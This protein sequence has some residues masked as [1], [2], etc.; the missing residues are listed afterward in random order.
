MSGSTVTGTNPPPTPTPNPNNDA[1]ITSDLTTRRWSYHSLSIFHVL[2]PLTLTFLYLSAYSVFSDGPVHE[3]YR[4]RKMG[5][6]LRVPAHDLLMNWAEA[7][8]DTTIPQNIYIPPFPVLSPTPFMD[9]KSPP[10][11]PLLFPFSLLRDFSSW[12][13]GD[14]YP[15]ST[16]QQF[17]GNNPPYYMLK[18]HLSSG[19]YGATPE[20]SP[21]KNG[22]FGSAGRWLSTPNRILR[23]FRW[24]LTPFL[25]EAHKNARE[26][27]I[28][29]NSDPYIL[30][31]GGRGVYLAYPSDKE[32]ILSIPPKCHVTADYTINSLFTAAQDLLNSPD[33]PAVASGQTRTAPYLTAS[34]GVMHPQKSIKATGTPKVKDVISNLAFSLSPL[35]DALIIAVWLARERWLGADSEWAPY[36]R[37]LPGVQNLSLEE[38]E[39]VVKKFEGK[40]KRFGSEKQNPKKS[41]FTRKM[42]T[43]EELFLNE[44]PPPPQSCGWMIDQ[45]HLKT[46]LQ[47][48]HEKTGNKLDGW[49]RETIGVRD[50]VELIAAGMAENVGWIVT[51]GIPAKDGLVAGEMVKVEPWDPTVQREGITVTEM[52]M[53]AICTVTNRGIAGLEHNEIK[54]PPTNDLY[55]QFRTHFEDMSL[56]KGHDQPP[57]PARVRLVPIMDMVNHDSDSVG[58]VELDTKHPP[59]STANRSNSRRKW[60]ATIL[61]ISGP[62]VPE[63][64]LKSIFDDR[65]DATIPIRSDTQPSGGASKIRDPENDIRLSDENLT[66]LR[67]YYNSTTHYAKENETPGTF[68]IYRTSPTQTGELQINYNSDGFSFLDWFLHFGF[69]PSSHHREY[70]MT[71]NTLGSYNVHPVNRNEFK[72]FDGD[73]YE[74]HEEVVMIEKGQ[75][76]RNGRIFELQE[77]RSKRWRRERGVEEDAVIVDEY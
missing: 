54:Q 39:R 59:T 53:W 23:Q 25:S 58:Y 52:L 46:A 1:A 29:S 68:V 31:G 64:P 17:V 72:G 60:N 56:K 26:R 77:E 73:R 69:I 27:Q 57:K 76:D 9:V 51:G 3:V 70:L 22:I 21:G 36:I 49:E 65:S 37:T 71:Q 13:F 20:I 67:R 15:R 30:S 12:L 11:L 7:A 62:H 6:P 35:D 55:R 10:P 19:Y 18:R 4:G 33:P 34:A 47:K 66:S 50:Y 43:A 32:T 8:C 44:N 24:F 45:K 61:E 42:P 14:T 75:P 2:I 16:L 41:S 74:E 40:Q 48:L 38:W 63:Y 5:P 28:K